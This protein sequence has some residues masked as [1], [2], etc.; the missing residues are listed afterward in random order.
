MSHCKDNHCIDKCYKKDKCH[1]D[2]DEKCKRGKRG[3]DGIRGPTGPTGAS[4][5]A[6]NT[7]A[8]GPTGPIGNGSDIQ[9]ASGNPITTTTLLGGLSD[10]YGLVGFGNSASFISGFANPIDL[11]GNITG[12]LLNFAYVAPRDGTITSIYGF[13]S[14]TSAVIPVGSTVTVHTQLYESASPTSNLF[15]PIVAAN[16]NLAAAFSSVATLG[17][18]AT[19]SNTGLS[20][21]VTAGL[22]YVLVVYTT[23]TGSLVTSVAGY[24]SA[25]MTVV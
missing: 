21:P 13:M 23:A 2:S 24:I 20:I 17:T 25:G 8:T 9:F 22:R 3:Y 15:A 10:T 6:T 18:V 19:G 1:K 4:G 16:V 12:P 5:L 7:G 14:V 11:T